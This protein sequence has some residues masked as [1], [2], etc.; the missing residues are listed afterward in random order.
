MCDANSRPATTEAKV[1]L[2]TLRELLEQ[3]GT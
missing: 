1:F 3:T 2:A